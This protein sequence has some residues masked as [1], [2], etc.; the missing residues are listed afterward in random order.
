MIIRHEA[1]PSGSKS[2]NLAPNSI[3]SESLSVTSRVS[4]RLDSKRYLIQFLTTMRKITRPRKF[5]KGLTALDEKQC[6]IRWPT[7]TF[8]LGV[9]RKSEKGFLDPVSPHCI[10]R[11][12]LTQE[13]QS[14]SEP[15]AFSSPHR[16]QIIV[17]PPRHSNVARDFCSACL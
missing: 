6:F 17:L 1:T 10:L 12:K 2:L 8:S 11:Q 13:S 14:F 5:A 3:E 16:L 9:R 15:I 7:T 4:P